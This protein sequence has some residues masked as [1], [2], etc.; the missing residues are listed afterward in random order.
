[1]HTRQLRLGAGS[2]SDTFYLYAA[3]AARGFGDGFAAIILP[4]YLLVPHTPPVMSPRIRVVVA[5]P[6]PPKATV[7]PTRKYKRTRR[8]RR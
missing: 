6:E 5:E 8:G 2:R 3:R 7:P 4:A 1:M